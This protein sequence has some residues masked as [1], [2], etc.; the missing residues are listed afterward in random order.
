[1]HRDALRIL[2]E[3]PAF[4]A[5]RIT[6]AWTPEA[7]RDAL[8]EQIVDDLNAGQVRALAIKQVGGEIETH[9]RSQVRAIEKASI[10]RPR[11]KRDPLVMRAE[12]QAALSEVRVLA[13]R[14]AIGMV[15]ELSSQL[16]DAPI[17]LG[18]GVEVLTG[19]ATADELAMR[20]E[21][22]E[23]KAIGSIDS[24]AFVA[25]LQNLLARS[26]KPTLRDVTQ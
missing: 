9:A 21:M 24:L 7:D 16:L 19:D 2:A 12:V 1:M 6:Q 13:E 4:V 23:G 10:R 5:G 25:A 17:S 8:A 11:I 26:G 22:L 18:N 3:L 14:R 15:I 20:A